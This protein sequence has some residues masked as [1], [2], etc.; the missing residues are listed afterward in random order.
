MPEDFQT[1]VQ[2]ERDR[3]NSQREQIFNQQQ[4]LEEK[5]KAVNNELRAIEAYEKTK[6]G[7][8]AAQPRQQR[9]GQGGRRG[10]KRE[11]LVK[12]VGENPDG[13][14]RREIIEK[15]GLKGDKSGEMSVSNALSALT[16]A[17]QFSRENGRYRGA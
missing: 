11:Q 4:D 8:G 17:N 16:K 14:T 9:R 5:L 15:M 3:L 1:F 6:A 10:G 2:Q 7:K 13:L 12:L